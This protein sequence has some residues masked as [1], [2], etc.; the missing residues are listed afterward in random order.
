MR[1]WSKLFH[2]NIAQ[3]FEAIKCD[4]YYYIAMEYCAGEDLRTLIN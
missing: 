2:P 3:V 4:E 1:I